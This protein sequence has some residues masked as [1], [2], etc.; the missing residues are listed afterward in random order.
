MISHGLITGA[1]V[2]LSGVLY[3]RGHTYKMSEY[4]GLAARTPEFAGL[5]AVAAFAALGLPGFS[6]FVAEIQIFTGSLSTATVA[7]AAAI[8]AIV[9]TAALFLL[10]LQR[11]FSRRRALAGDLFHEISAVEATAIVPLLAISLVSLNACGVVKRLRREFG[12]V[13]CGSGC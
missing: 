9:I 7:T 5:T 12:S 2:L 10:A 3:D 1:L 11:L 6:G 4:G 8:F 13:L